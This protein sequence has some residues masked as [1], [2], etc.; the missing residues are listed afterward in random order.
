MKYIELCPEVSSLVS[1]ALSTCRP[2]QL[3]AGCQKVICDVQLPTF[4]CGLWSFG[5][6]CKLLCDVVD[7]VQ[8][9]IIS[10]KRLE[11]W[12]KQ[13]PLSLFWAYMLCWTASIKHFTL[14]WG[15]PNATQAVGAECS[16]H[17][18]LINL[19]W[20]YH[21]CLWGIYFV[22]DLKSLCISYFVKWHMMYVS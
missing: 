12:R 3:L 1:V 2:Y 5:Y 17:V 4:R 21:W 10:W 9:A 22:S 11:N 7:K 6:W 15:N 18:W 20:Q 13:F 19:Q 14:V 16:S 8:L